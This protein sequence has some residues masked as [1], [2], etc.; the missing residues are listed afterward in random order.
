MLSSLGHTDEQKK[1]VTRLK[2]F[3]VF[4]LISLVLVV[5][6]SGSIMAAPQYGG[7]VKVRAA[8]D[9]ATLD[10]FRVG[11]DAFAWD[12]SYAINVYPF[13]LGPDG[14]FI[15][16]AA[17][18][19]ETPDDTTIIFNLRDNVYFHDGSKMTAE[20]FYYTFTVNTDPDSGSYW[21]EGLRGLVEDFEIVDEYTFKLELVEPWAP[22]FYSLLFPI[23]PKDAYEAKAD[24]FALE[25]VGAGPFKVVEWVP[26]QHLILE[27]FDEFYD[28]RAY[29]D[30]VIF[31]V[32]D[33]DTA[34]MAFLD[35][36]IDVLAVGTE[37][38]DMVEDHP[39]L[40]VIRK[41]G[42]SWFYLGVNQTEGPLSDPKVREAI[43]YG[44][45]REEI[46][47]Y[48]FHGEMKLSTGPIV[49]ISW[50]YNPDVRSYPYNPGRSIRLLQEA[51]YGDG[52]TIELKC[53]TGAA[54]V[55]E[56]VQTQL[57]LVG[58]NLEMV[59]MEWGLLS[60]D[61]RDDKFELHYRAWTRQTDPERGINR[62]F[63]SDSNINIAGY[64]NPRV[65][66]LA[67]KAATTLD[68]EERKAMYFEIQ[69]ILAED[70]P[71]IF[72][73]HGIHRSAYNTRVQ[74]FDTDPYYC[75]RVYYHMWVE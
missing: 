50:A 46:I 72:L 39:N 8:S 20:D 29:L 28:G 58:I 13:I 16:D 41:P 56:L 18:S 24:D 4:V 73:W 52:V 19:W 27:A 25:P 9:P 5:A 48:H 64:N 38:L 61:V 21:Y 10:P 33:Y 6:L 45:N 7:E 14:D 51:G 15:P 3:H 32:M 12:I 11:V 54:S 70:L 59:P 68:L 63:V 57:A 71:A 66:E 2:R 62:Q 34:L 74:N 31:Q 42:T 49:P 30:R 43:S 60:D 55:M 53:S 22:I 44:I 67:H 40:D 75:Y 26:D 23:V 17:E 69:E 47:E 36:D 1:E 65:D 35:E 37:D